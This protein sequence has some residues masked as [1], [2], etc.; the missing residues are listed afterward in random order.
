MSRTEDRTSGSPALGSCGEGRGGG[1][2]LYVMA[3]GARAPAQNLS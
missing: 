1:R 2:C 3:L